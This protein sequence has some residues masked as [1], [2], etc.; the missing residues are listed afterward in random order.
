[1][2][3]AD[4]SGCHA[5]R[6]RYALGTKGPTQWV[7]VDIWYISGPQSSSHVLTFGP[8]HVPYRYLDPLGKQE[9][10]E[11]Q[12]ELLGLNG[13]FPGDPSM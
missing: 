9:S 10:C 5:T 7:H 11:D 8:M 1:M 6:R 2:A 4:G 12:H 13:P 3:T